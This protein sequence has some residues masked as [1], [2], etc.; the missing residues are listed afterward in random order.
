MKESDSYSLFVV[1]CTFSSK[2][3][4][5][6]KNNFQSLELFHLMFNYLIMLE[7][8]LISLIKIIFYVIFYKN[9]FILI[10]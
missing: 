10:P 6:I 7:E 1:Y 3:L 5:L 2:K 9:Q 8:M 4:L